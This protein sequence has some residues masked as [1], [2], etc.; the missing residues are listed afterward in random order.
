MIKNKKPVC[1][2]RVKDE[3]CAP[4]LLAAD[5]NALVLEAVPFDDGGG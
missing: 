4:G 2:G 3:N 5:E 1:C